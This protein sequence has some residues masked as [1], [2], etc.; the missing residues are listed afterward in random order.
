MSVMVVDDKTISVLAKAFVDYNIEFE[1]DSFT[2]P[3]FMGVV[4]DADEMKQAIGE[5]LLK[6]SYVAYN[7]KYKE[8]DAPHEYKFEDLEIN[9]GLVI[10]CLR[11]YEYQ[12]CELD[13]WFEGNKIRWSI[14]RLRDTILNSLIEQKGYEI[15]YGYYGQEEFAVPRF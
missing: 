2:M 9:Y 14:D 15:P 7:E 6:E 10:G 12:V 1:A 3:S 5:R 8:T 4:F 13:D 11:F